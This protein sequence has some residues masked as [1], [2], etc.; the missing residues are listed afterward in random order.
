VIKV[1]DASRFTVDKGIKDGATGVTVSKVTSPEVIHTKEVVQGGEDS[2]TYDVFFTGPQ[3]ND[4]GALVA[5]ICSSSQWTHYD[6]MRYGVSV[7]EMTK[8]DSVEVQ[9]ISMTSP[10]SPNTTSLTYEPVSGTKIQ[11]G[12]WRLVFNDKVRRQQLVYPPASNTRRDGTEPISYK[13]GEDASTIQDDL[14]DDTYGIAFDD[15]ITVTRSG[16]GFFGE[17]YGYTYSI[18]FDNIHADRTGDEDEF[19]VI[20]ESGIS[21][22]LYRPVNEYTNAAYNFT[23]NKNDLQTRGPYTG[24]V[25]TM[26]V[27]VI[28]SQY[29]TF[30]YFKCEVPYKATVSNCDGSVQTIDTAAAAKV[31]AYDNTTATQIARHEFY[32]LGETTITL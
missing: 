24:S 11:R 32:N 9:V 12:M 20:T 14:R 29:N 16:E 18:V 31:T 26:Y 3:I 8:G 27:V 19:S 10:T 5:Q 1:I 2:Y 25:D 4:H 22:P 15:K 23:M 30:D 7:E 21:S 13:W 17:S 6:G 28:T